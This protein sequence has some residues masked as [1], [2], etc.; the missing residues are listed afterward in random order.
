[1]L[2]AITVAA[3]LAVHLHGHSLPAPAR[4]IA[5]D[6]LWASMIYWVSSA[7]APAAPRPWRILIALGVCFCVELSQ[8]VHTEALNSMRSTLLGHLLLG[9]DFDTRDLLAYAVGVAGVAFID[10]RMTG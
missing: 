9:S 6:M 4:D 3:G 2:A 5:G 7:V 8:L 1:M 10:H